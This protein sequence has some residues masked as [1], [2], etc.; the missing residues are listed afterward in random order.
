MS[1]RP[2][3]FRQSDLTRA[4]KAARAAGVEI[5]RVEIERDGRMIVVMNKGDVP[6]PNGGDTNP[7]D[8]VLS[9]VADK[10]RPS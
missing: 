10:K 7:W 3:T 2:C 9:D 8:E 5:E 6:Q 1:R 4:I